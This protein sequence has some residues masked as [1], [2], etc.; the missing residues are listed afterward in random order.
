[1][2]IKNII[3]D[4]GGVLS[5]PKTGHWFITTNFWEILNLDKN[6]NIDNMKSIMKKY[7]HLLTQ[8]P[9]TE[10]EE[11]E[12]FSNFY[13]YVL[14]EFK[15]NNLS[16]EIT[17]SLASDC[18]YNDDKYI[19]YDDVDKELDN[20]SK[21]YNLYMITDAW[22]SSFRVLNN[23]DISKYF[24]SIMVSSIESKIKTDGLFEIF[25]DKNKNIKPEESIFIDDR[26]VILDKAKECNFNVLQMDRNYEIKESKYIIIHELKEVEKHLE[27]I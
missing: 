25:L 2:K 14:K 10:K 21:K 26:R 9:K 15:Y 11:Y 20:L 27:D 5:D 13:Y 19:F 3:F 4:N 8:D 24:K 6:T 23:K 22:P 16:K 12:M 7:I 1:M 18:V 17:N